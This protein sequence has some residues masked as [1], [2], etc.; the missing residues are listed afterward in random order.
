MS[1][2]VNEPGIRLQAQRRYDAGAR[3]RSYDTTH[4]SRPDAEPTWDDLGYEDQN[5]IIREWNEV[6]LLTEYAE[7]EWLGSEEAVIES[8]TNPWLKDEA[9]N[10]ID[11]A[12]E[13]DSGRILISGA[14]C[15]SCCDSIMPGLLAPHGSP[16][17][18][19]RC[20]NC[21]TYDGDLQA[22]AALRDEL[23]PEATVWFHGSN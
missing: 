14:G 7:V 18:I 20:D 4:T 9:G 5:A 16:S 3:R 23:F 1:I 22:A 8:E 13:V 15:Y 21:A 10:E 19:E 6:G 2:D 12:Q 17:G 11:L